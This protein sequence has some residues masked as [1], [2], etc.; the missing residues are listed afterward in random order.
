VGSIT[1]TRSFA[2]AAV[3]PASVLRGIGIDSEELLDESTFE[4][5]A[6]LVIDEGEARLLQGER[7]LQR[8][9]LLFSAKESLYKC[10]APIAGVFFEFADA[11]VEEIDDDHGAWRV[12][13]LTDLP[14]FARGSVYEGRF[15]VG[16]DVVHT[17]LELAS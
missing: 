5:V 3:A 2:S 17:A 12:R 13:L 11:R 8:A 10:L 7:R 4:E 6:P 1:H 15:A 9:T 16:P 14:G